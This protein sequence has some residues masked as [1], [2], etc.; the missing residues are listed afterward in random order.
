MVI[1]QYEYYWIDLD[2]TVGSEM[3]KRRPCLVVSP[4]EM[5]KGLKT[6]IVAPLTSTEKQY[7]TRVMTK[8]E[9]RTGWIVLDQL[10]CVDQSRLVQ[11]IGNADKGTIGEVKRILKEMLVD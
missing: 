2:P 1:R 8:V 4:V 6:V 10:R 11:K 5:N 9:D 3:K 7:P